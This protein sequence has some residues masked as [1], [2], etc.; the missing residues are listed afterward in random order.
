M[1]RF[2]NLEFEEK[3]AKKE[4]A[5]LG[6]PVR[7]CQFFNE[8]GGLDWL[9]GDFEG[10]L[11]N[12]S[13]ALE[14][15]SAF[16]P[17]WFGQVRML[18]EMA[19]YHEAQLWADKALELFPEHPELLAAKAVATARDERRDQ[20]IAY[21]DN[22]ISKQKITSY[23]WLARAEVMLR[24][25][26]RTAETCLSNAISIAGN[27]LPIVRLDAGRTLLHQSSHAKALEYLRPAASDL[28]KAALVWYELGCCQAALGLPEGKIA[29]KQC[30]QLRPDWGQAKAALERFN[31][32]GP[33]GWL[34]SRFR[35]LRGR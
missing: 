9:A 8:R 35:R 24:R 12:Y 14:Q 1:S 34:R 18:I 6:E 5:P 25:R 29:L 2:S 17:G 23:V 13:R 16:F 20:A 15:N 32:Q 11:R 10:A 33:L 7:D 3:G 19:E 21:S 27:S 22:S 30:L 31:R 28:P 26:H 4:A